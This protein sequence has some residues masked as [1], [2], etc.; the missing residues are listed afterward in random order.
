MA[1]VYERELTDK[2]LDY[3]SCF[4]KKFTP[5]KIIQSLK[6]QLILEVEMK[7]VELQ[8]SGLFTS[9]NNPSILFFAHIIPIISSSTRGTDIECLSI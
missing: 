6:P 2:P 3:E 4:N 5:D 1:R 8:S 7:E 9:L